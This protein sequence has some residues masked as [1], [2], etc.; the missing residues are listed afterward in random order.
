MTTIKDGGPWANEPDNATFDAHGFKCEIR[1]VKSSGH[2]CGYV[3]VPN[4]HPWY[5]KQYNDRV[6]PPRDLIERPI[7]IDKIGAF[8][9]FCASVIGDDIRESCEIVLLVDVHGG[10]TYSQQGDADLE[11]LWVFGFD[12]AHAGDL[13]P[14]TAD[15]FGSCGDETYRD[16]AYVK[17][18]TESMARQLAAIAAREVE[19]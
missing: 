16:F 3:G 2:L 7:D 11:G 12:C 8:N 5:G 14:V 17:S 1:R 19:S 18:E 15:R 9:L 13:C 4:S 10:L 6:K